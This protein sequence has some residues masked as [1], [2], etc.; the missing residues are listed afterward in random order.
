[1][2][3]P[4]PGSSRHLPSLAWVRGHLTGL[5]PWGE[6]RAAAFS[7]N[8]SRLVAP[9]WQWSREHV[10]RVYTSKSRKSGFGFVGELKITALPLRLCSQLHTQTERTGFSLFPYFPVS[11]LK[12]APRNSVGNYPFT[13]SSS[14]LYISGA[15]W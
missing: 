14:S 11:S 3:Q 15:G 13:V 2:A 10:T 5:L 9:P 4:A 7:P 1:M 12:S 6:V 8:P